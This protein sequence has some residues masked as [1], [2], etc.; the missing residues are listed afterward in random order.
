MGATD[1]LDMPGKEHLCYEA[2]CAP[3]VN[4]GPVT[5]VI[6]IAVVRFRPDPPG[7]A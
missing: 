5:T 7:D 3:L 2:L 1:R 6:M 4:G